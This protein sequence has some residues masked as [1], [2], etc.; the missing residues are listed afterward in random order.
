MSRDPLGMWGDAGNQGNAQ[1]Y[2]GS[3]PVNR[4]DPLGL[5]PEPDYTKSFRAPE[6]KSDLARLKEVNK[7]VLRF[8][9]EM[10]EMANGNTYPKDVPDRTARVKKDGQYPRTNKLALREKFGVIYE[11]KDGVLRLKTGQVSAGGVDW[12]D[13]Q[14]L[15]DEIGKDCG[16]VVATLHAH[17]RAG[18]KLWSLNVNSRVPLQGGGFGYRQGGVVTNVLGPSEED[19]K[20]LATKEGWSAYPHV[21]LGHDD[22]YFDAEKD[23]IHTWTFIPGPKGPTE[24]KS[25]IEGPMYDVQRGIYE[26]A[27]AVLGEIIKGR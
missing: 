14:A 12:K 23:D 11:D 3:N 1:S 15:L 18:V 8:R 4:A 6:S 17:P 27:G 13:L 16:K 10:S 5:A 24:T 21:V 9:K 26:S 20:S 25:V 7:A 19:R 2:C 22:E